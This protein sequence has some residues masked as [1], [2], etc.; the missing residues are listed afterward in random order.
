MKRTILAILLAL[1]ALLTLLDRFVLV[2]LFLRRAGVPLLLAA[3]EALAIVGTG[4]LLRRAKRVD[5]PLDFLLG[6]PVFGTLLFLVGTLKIA[7][8]TL[9]PLLVLGA[10]AGVVYLL[11]QYTDD[12]ESES[13]VLEWPAL[14]V[15]AVLACGFVVAQAP[16]ASL[17][18]LA[19]HLA[20]PH[21]WV[22]EGRALEL[23]LLSHSYFP[24]GIESADLLPLTLLGSTGGGLAS[25]FLH[26]FAA[27]ATTLLV[28][29]RTQSWLAT[30]A[31]VTTPALAI[32]A[33]WSLVEWPLAGLFVA[34]Y[35]ALES[36][37][38][39]TASAA[40]AAG[41]LTKYTFLPFALIAWALK[42]R[43]PKWTA[44]LGLV[45]FLRN[46]LLTA[47]PFA[48]FLSGDAPHVSGFRALALADY[49]FEAKFV[50]EALGAAILALPVF[51]TGGIAIASA[52]LALALFFLAPSSRILVPFLV[53]P[54][55]SAAPALR[56]RVL[57]ALMAIAIVVQ[58]FL[59]V[60]FTSRGNA[61]AL[62]SGMALDE[63][64]LRKERP[65]YAS[66]E[67][68]NLV[69]PPDSRTLVVGLGETYWI[70]RK[71]RGGGNF[72]GPRIS[73][74]LDLPAADALHQ[75][76]RTDGIT[77]VAIVALPLATQ[78]EQ[79]REERQTT[80]SAEAQRMLAQT[81]DRYAASVISRGNVTMFT[82]R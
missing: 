42:R 26:F 6:Y 31:I 30:A 81:L 82:L 76:L 2:E 60:W 47:N 72:D 10:I 65:S 9:V 69:L 15:F 18:E 12:T 11:K 8:W 29:R 68:L 56:R 28:V 44:L 54:S 78:V 36:D 48:P 7:A 59:V 66:I 1:F 52:L 21:A 49:V 51:A 33:G 58:T 24:L 23:P 39:D 55:L 50:D 14:F 79:K 34:L 77:H 38:R 5:V 17:D 25:H 13:L 62:L 57:S 45:F 70:D 35:V 19:Y 53:V 80:L 43:V 67:W 40:T 73:R 16:P 75:R 61:F 41:L 71:V 4:A 37:D 74:Y 63:D 64:Y 22:Q 27:I 20:V 46:L 3:V 32:T